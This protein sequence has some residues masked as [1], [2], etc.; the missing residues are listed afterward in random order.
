MMTMHQK[1]YDS[2]VGT[3]ANL[4][5]DWQAYK[6]GIQANPGAIFTINSYN[7]SISDAG[8]KITIGKTGILEIDL[9]G[10]T[11]IISVKYVSNLKGE[12]IIDIVGTRV[13][14]ANAGGEN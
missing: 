8:S 14:T 13:S 1:I 2:S 4:I 3:D 9:E 12:C 10:K 7:D 11:S 6:L 5:Q